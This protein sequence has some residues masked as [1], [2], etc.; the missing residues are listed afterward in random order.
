MLNPNI[1]Q[2]KIDEVEKMLHCRDP[3]YG[4]LTYKCPEC[5]TTKTVPLACKSRICPQCGKK[6]T[7]QWA[8]ELANRLFAVP[9]RHMVFTM[10]EELRV[11]FEANQSLFKVLMDA[12]SNTMQ[13][14]LK[15]K[16]RAVPGIVCVLHP[17][18]KELN[19]N[20]HVHVL[21]TE[22]GLS[23]AGEWVPVSFLEYGALRRIWQYQLLSMVRR[24]LPRSVENKC[25]IDRLFRE[26]KDG[27]YVYAKRRVSKP[28]HIASYIGRYLRH[29]A[30][31]ESRISEFNVETNMV[32]YWYVDEHDVKQFITLH[33][34]E[35][36]GRLVK[37]IP[38]KNLKLIRYYGLYSRRT[39][40]VLQKVLTCLSRENV[41]VKFKRVVVCCSNCG[42]SMGLVGVTRLDGVGGLVYEAWSGDSG[43]DDCW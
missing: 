12:V 26:H 17:Y 23:K 41:S 28:R 4:F 35:F 7:D 1:S 11:K 42:K 25:L 20:P 39:L 37:L 21:L 36:I 18:G 14:M 27:F 19:L 29:P 31:A 13:Q 34:L 3:K 15:D 22:G 24:V 38:D 32:T 16:H 33:A 40:G 8:D 30:I 10:P 5:N 43:D 9:H 2:Y 6:Y